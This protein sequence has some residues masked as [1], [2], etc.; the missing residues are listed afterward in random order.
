MIF[1]YAFVALG[2]M[3]WLQDF[4]VYLKKKMNTEKPL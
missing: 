2:A 3:L 1:F 4:V